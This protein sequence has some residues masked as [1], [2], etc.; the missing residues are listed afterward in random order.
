M[1]REPKRAGFTLIE[2]LVVISIIIIVSGITIPLF[3]STRSTTRR[4]DATNSVQAALAAAREAAVERRTVVALEFVSDPAD[5]MRGDFMQLVDKSR[6]IEDADPKKEL[7]K[8][9]IGNPIPLPDFIK[10]D[11]EVNAASP[12]NYIG[13]SIEWTL[14]NGWDGD[15]NDYYDDWPLP[16]TAVNEYPDIAYRPDG[17]VA[18]Q[19]GTTDI[20]LVDASEPARNVIRVLPATGLVIRARHLQDPSA[21]EGPT[22]PRTTGWL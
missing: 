19:E 20:A 22:N 12:P 16:G 17:T 6:D 11:F 10:F 21:A 4:N 13:K 18:D 9:L 14:E 5:P 8:R 15:K 1:R 2:M 3:V 7:Q